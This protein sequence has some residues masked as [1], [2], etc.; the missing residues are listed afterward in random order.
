VGSISVRS[1]FRNWAK[2]NLEAIFV[3]ILASGE[4]M[5]LQC[6]CGLCAWISRV[7]SFLQHKD[8]NKFFAVQTAQTVFRD[9]ISLHLI[10]EKSREEGKIRCLDI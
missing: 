8:K 1:Q 10:T 4:V 9:V 2:F 3:L 5:A 7:T 6:H